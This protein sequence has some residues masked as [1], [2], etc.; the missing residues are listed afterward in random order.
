MGNVR[1][2]FLARQDQELQQT[3]SQTLTE[4][5]WQDFDISYY[6]AQDIHSFIQAQVA[7]LSKKNTFVAAEAGIIADQVFEQSRGM[8]QWVKLIMYALEGA[9]TKHEVLSTINHFPKKLNEAYTSTFNRLSQRPG[10]NSDRA[11]LVLKLLSVAYRSLTWEELAMAVKLQQKVD[12]IQHV[13]LQSMQDCI[14]FAE[15]ELETLKLEGPDYF[16]FLGPLLDIRCTTVTERSAKAGDT[17]ERPVTIVTMCHHSLQQWIDGSESLVDRDSDLWKQYHFTRIEA[18]HALASLSLVMLSSKSAVTEY[19]RT[20]YTPDNAQPFVNYSG[21]HVFAHVRAIG[22]SAPL[23]RMNDRTERDGP[24]KKIFLF[25]MAK[26]MLKHNL[27][28][29]AAASAALSKSLADIEMKQVRHLPKVVAVRRLKTVVLPASKS[30]LEVTSHFDEILGAVREL[31]MARKNRSNDYGED[32]TSES[33]FRDTALGSLGPELDSN[34]ALRTLE[35]IKSWASRDQHFTQQQKSRWEYQVKLLCKTTRHLRQLAILL[36]VDPVR[37]WIYAQVGETGIAPL[38]ALTYASEGSDA[39]LAASLLDREIFRKHDLTEQF[40]ASPDHPY[41]G[42]ITATS[43]ELSTKGYNGFDTT[44]YKE[45]IM[46]HYRISKWE[47]TRTRL[48]LA[49]MEMGAVSPYWMNTILKEWIFEHGLFPNDARDA[50]SAIQIIDQVPFQEVMSRV[51]TWR[52]RV[53]IGI[54]VGVVY[55]FKY[56]T[57][58]YPPLEGLFADAR[59]LVQ[60][61]TTVLRPTLQLLFSNRTDFLIALIFYF[62]RNR[63]A[64]WV[65]W[66]IRSN[67]LVDLKGIIRDPK[68]YIP[69]RITG[70]PFPPGWI[71]LIVIMVQ[72]TGFWYWIIFGLFDPNDANTIGIDKDLE[73]RTSFRID[74]AN[75]DTSTVFDKIKRA[76]LSHGPAWLD[77]FTRIICLEK[78]FLYSSYW[79]FDILRDSAQLLMTEFWNWSKALSYAMQ[80]VGFVY[81]RTAG[82][83]ALLRMYFWLAV[84]NRYKSTSLAGLVYRYIALPAWDKLLGASKE[85]FKYLVDRR[86]AWTRFLDSIE[87]MLLRLVRQL[88]FRTLVFCTAAGICAFAF[89]FRYMT[90]DPLGLHSA[91]Q[92]CNEAERLARKAAGTKDPMQFLG[93]HAGSTDHLMLSF[94]DQLVELD[95]EL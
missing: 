84:I 13:G 80:M 19:L 94:N 28:I 88:E 30:L 34:L 62:A 26:I 42:H 63:Y 85:F 5:P 47:W 43:H 36:S 74:W 11:I 1:L 82:L 41:Y 86:D 38:V 70:W 4:V 46:Q 39:Y 40:S 12:E 68:D 14:T 67:P 61:L 83:L 81:G 32:L 10:F 44:F 76:F 53:F 59:W 29:A 58:V 3:A 87:E 20:Y 17:I 31:M 51:L 93:W 54:E 72:E 45:S 57:H 48:L 33:P 23:Y 15:Q 64:P 55:S 60:M 89:L 49:A 37:A 9:K 8:F 73:R 75:A 92:S 90:A 6:N 24:Q 22:T 91:A 56:L 79:V 65:F 7:S 69:V 77:S 25:D 95:R 2:L 52:D 35:T 78:L 16:S 50:I 66:N 27:D 71:S 21:T 18:H